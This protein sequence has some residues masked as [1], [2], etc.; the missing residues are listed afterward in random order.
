[1]SLWPRAGIVIRWRFEPRNSARNVADLRSGEAHA[2]VRA[3][4]RRAFVIG[5]RGLEPRQDSSAISVASGLEATDSVVELS[6]LVGGSLG[7]GAGGTAGVGTGTSFLAGTAFLAGGSSL[8]P[9]R[10]KAE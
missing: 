3:R 7:V 9:R 6:V 1:M 2:S 10:R 4:V 5:F 8:I